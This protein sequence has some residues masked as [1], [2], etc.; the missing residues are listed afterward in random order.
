MPRRAITRPKPQPKPV[1]Q[2]QIDKLTT[3]L[4]YYEGR[5]HKWTAKMLRATREFEKAFK[6]T[7]RLK[8][9]IEK[10]GGQP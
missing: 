1:N 9:E 7:K 4:A 8:R 5:M 3:R 6:S 10:E 2:A